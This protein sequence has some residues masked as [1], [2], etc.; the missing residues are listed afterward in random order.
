MIDTLNKCYIY[1]DFAYELYFYLINKIIE[2]I[3]LPIIDNSIK[4]ILVSQII[5]K[6]YACKEII[7]NEQ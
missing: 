3:N 6:I 5:E 7:K 2:I 1:F 4:E